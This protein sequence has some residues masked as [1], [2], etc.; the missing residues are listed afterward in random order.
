MQSSLGNN[1]QN[2]IEMLIEFYEKLKK[3][4]ILLY[5]IFLI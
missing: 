1:N 3:G 2:G 5:A 4:L